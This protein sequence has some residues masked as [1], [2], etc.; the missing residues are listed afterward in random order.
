MK[1]ELQQQMQT[2]N[3]MSI[4]INRKQTFIAYISGIIASISKSPFYEN[5]VTRFENYNQ[6]YSEVLNVYL[7]K[8]LNVQ[9]YVLYILYDNH[10]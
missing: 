9:L 4:S 2:K 3:F 5:I 7:E 8:S 10:P 1:L 6:F